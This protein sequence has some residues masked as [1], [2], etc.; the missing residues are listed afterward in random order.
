MVWGFALVNIGWMFVWFFFASRL[1]GYRLVDFLKDTVPFA[2]T[3]CGVMC[4]TYL[5]TRS[6]SNLLLLFIARMAIA[7]LLYYAVMR[8]AHVKILDDCLQFI[9]KKFKKK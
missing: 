3:A 2:L 5:A 8:I 1:S 9:A 4:I 6:L 7:A